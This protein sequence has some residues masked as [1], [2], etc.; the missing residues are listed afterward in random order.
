[1]DLDTVPALAVT[2]MDRLDESLPGDNVTDEFVPLAPVTGDGFAPTRLPELAEN[3]IVW[4]GIVVLNWS[5]TVT[6]KLTVEALADDKNALV[7]SKSTEA[8]A[9]AADEPS[10]ATE[11]VM[12]V[13][14]AS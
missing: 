11:M 12:E 14:E 5:L 13:L 2:V 10:T 6:A 4:P 1:M 7:G 8:T 9:V 3:V